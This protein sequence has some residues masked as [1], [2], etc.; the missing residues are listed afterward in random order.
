MER[1]SDRDRERERRKSE[2]TKVI[3]ALM[4]H[5]LERESNRPCREY[6]QQYCF[7]T[8]KLAKRLDLSYSENKKETIIMWHGSITMATIAIMSEWVKVALLCP[9]LCDLIDYTVHGVL[10]TRVL[11]WVAYPFSSGSSPPRN[12]TRVSCIAGRF[13]THWAKREAQ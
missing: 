10:Q 2:D 8:L 9:T 3:Q 1:D 12:Q 5:I 13:S 6:G 7:I 4:V 11:E